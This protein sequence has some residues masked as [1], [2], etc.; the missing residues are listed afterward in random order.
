MK[1]SFDESGE[2]KEFIIAQLP[3]ETEKALTEIARLNGRT[4]EQEATFILKSHLADLSGGA[5]QSKS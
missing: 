3:S 5:E 1:G 4:L 2:P